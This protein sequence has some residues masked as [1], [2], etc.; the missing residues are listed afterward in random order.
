[1]ADGPFQA[2]LL[3]RLLPR[4]GGGFFDLQKQGELYYAMACTWVRV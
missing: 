3:T 1:M 2:S 4:K